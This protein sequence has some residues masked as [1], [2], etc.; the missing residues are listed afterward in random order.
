[1]ATKT[2]LDKNQAIT[3]VS[4]Y[5]ERLENLNANQKPIK[6]ADLSDFVSSDYTLISNGQQVSRSLNEY[7]NRLT[8]FQKKYSRMEISSFIEE[9]LFADNKV[10]VYY[11]IDLTPHSGQKKQ[12]FV[13][14]IATIE[15]N[16]ITRWT[17]VVTERGA[18]DWDK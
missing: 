8:K 5:L 15:D 7:L 17:Q 4:D 18:C 16:K 9:P 14:G 3:F 10:A 2:K 6:A 1:M 11:T 12:V 13:Q